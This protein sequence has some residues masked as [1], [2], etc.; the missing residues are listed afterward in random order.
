[1]DLERRRH[2]AGMPPVDDAEGAQDGEAH[3]RQLEERA[4]VLSEVRADASNRNSRDRARGLWRAAKLGDERRKLPPN[5][6][7][8]D[9]VTRR[10]VSRGEAAFIQK[11]FTSQELMRTVREV[12]DE[13]V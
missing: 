7:P 6:V 5:V 12:L 3:Q 2:G 11:P 4:L 13:R 9:E 1:M 8:D 10:G